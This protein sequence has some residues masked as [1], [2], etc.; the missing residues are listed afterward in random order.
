MR[1]KVGIQSTSP[2]IYSRPRPSPREI[3]PTVPNFSAG[4]AEPYLQCYYN[5]HPVTVADHDQSLYAGRVYGRN[6]LTWPVR[7]V[8]SFLRSWDQVYLVSSTGASMPLEH[9]GSQ[10]ECRRRENRG[11]VGGEGVGS[12]EVCAPFQKI[13]E[14]FISKWCDTVHSGCVN[15][16]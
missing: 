8:P 10:V 15:C 6:R 7:R 16:F 11:A 5:L 13:Y 3:P 12:G 2:E 9:W 1:P 4:G 14:F